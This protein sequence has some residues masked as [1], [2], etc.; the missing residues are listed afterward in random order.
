M[1]DLEEI[2]PRLRNTFRDRHDIEEDEVR[3]EIPVKKPRKK[4]LSQKPILD[5]REEEVIEADE[6]EEEEIAPRLKNTRNEPRDKKNED[7]PKKKRAKKGSFAEFILPVKDFFASEKVH[8]I[9]GLFLLLS[10]VYLTIAF[11]SFFFTWTVDQ[12][13]VMGSW[14][15]L[16]S[17]DES[18]ANWLGKLGAVISHSFIHAGFGIAALAFPLVALVL[19][20]RILMKVELLPLARTLKW[21]V[22]G[23]LFLSCAL[24]YLFHD[25][26]FYL[27]GT[28]GFHLSEWLNRSLGAVGTGALLA[29]TFLTF[30][31]VNFNISFEFFRKPEPI[32][33]V[34][35]ASL[36][37]V[38]LRTEMKEEYSPQ[39]E[40]TLNREET[41]PPPE[42]TEIIAPA[43]T[44][45]TIEPVPDEV[46]PV[47][48]P[49]LHSISLGEENVMLT[50]EQ[51][52]F[53]DESDEDY[54]KKAEELVAQFGEYDPTLELGEY[55]FPGVDLLTTYESSQDAVSE[56]ELNANAKRIVQTLK[57]YGIEIEKIK[58]TIGPTITLYEIVPKAGVRISKIKSL[59]NDI[60][61]SLAALGIRIIAPIPGKGTIGI[62]V[63]NLHPEMVP[64][65]TVL[66]SEKFQS[67]HM[68][69]PLALGRT[70]ANE[71]FIA[72]LAKMPHLL[73][74]GATGQ[75]KSVG[76]NMILSSLIYK[77]HPS[78]LKLVL[79]DPK[80]VE[81]TLYNKI[82][83][84]FLA[85]LPDAEKP[86]ITDSKKVINTLN[87]L[88]IEMEARYELLEMVGLRNIKEYNAEFVK[89]K[90]NPNNGHKFLPYIVV[91]IDEF[92]DFI[93]EAGKEVEI[94]IARL[95]QKARAVGIHLII[96]TQRPSVD[97]ITGTIKA[98]F[99]ARIAFRVTS[100]ID[101]R[102]ILDQGGADQL[103]GK[104]DMLL[105]TGSDLIRLQCA[106][107][108]TPEVARITDFIGSQKGFSTAHILPEYVGE[109]EGGGGVSVDA[110]DRDPLFEE[111]AR[112][113][114]THQQ[115]SA[116]LLQ[117]K[118]QLGYNRAGRIVDQL[119]NAGVIG[120]FKGS[121]AREVLIKDVLTLEQFLK[122]GDDTPQ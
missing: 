70:I 83:R 87:S 3:E 28:F 66:G 93:T 76:V 4:K 47:D 105:S 51:N 102:T 65:R 22:F 13:K 89:R 117:R 91:V 17:S 71:T 88:V 24:G 35:E 114:V 107:I 63:P 78:Q 42:V 101:S 68:D 48:P 61:L 1:E 33:P 38:L 2:K 5:E 36:Q 108:D 45:N 10:S 6:E 82:E 18:A 73:I 118:L 29:F 115:G 111:A 80:K 43:E 26:W 86:I 109:D 69:L 110:A 41:P 19:G 23:L 67:S 40:V 55:R 46:K 20:I 74:A 106:F 58:A 77:K 116:S 39:V 99:P 34:N 31:V 92:A 7:K 72:D 103:I 122:K 75:G 90:L 100:K 62:E 60:A 30:L 53:K 81:L 96:A 64:A 50:V 16:F 9:A 113:I 32:P 79:I 95:A 98:N 54:S 85:K 12:D 11:V 94:P 15:D 57:D 104:G 27:G 8:K 52:E 49:L 56:E 59:E 44:E 97:V 21:S 37:N 120:P 25:K 112:I 14:A 121:K 84:H 119:E